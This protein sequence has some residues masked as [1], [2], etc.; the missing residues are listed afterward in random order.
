MG[1]RLVVQSLPV[2]LRSRTAAPS[3]ETAATTIAVS[4]APTAPVFGFWM[5]GLLTVN[6]VSAVAPSKCTNRVCSPSESVL[7][8]LPKSSMQVLPSQALYRLL[9][10]GIPSTATAFKSANG[11][12]I[13]KEAAA[14]AA[15]VC[16]APERNSVSASYGI[17][18]ML[19]LTT[20]PVSSITLPRSK[21][22]SISSCELVKVKVKEEPL[23]FHP[24]SL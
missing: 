21:N 22:G 5:D 6:V 20:V 8:K 3:T 13:R 2:F 12:S 14:P 16:P 4:P 9:S 15:T 1:T 17:T 11:R 23:P 19:L 7:V 18:V 24:A 10:S